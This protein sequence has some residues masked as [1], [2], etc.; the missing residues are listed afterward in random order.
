[1]RSRL[2]V[3]FLILTAACNRTENNPVGPT[4][5]P[6]PGSTIVYSAVGASDAMGIGSSVPCLPFEDCLTGM[7]YVAVATRQLRSQSF[8][9]RLQNL[10]IP[11]AVIGRDFEALGQ[12]YNRVIVGN[13]IEREMPFVLTDSTVVT[14]FAGV[15]DIITV[16]SALGGGAGGAN[17]QAYLDAQV[18]AFANDYS[19]LVNGVRSRAPNTRVIALNVPNVAAIPYF[20]TASLS[21][22]QA[23]QRLS[24]G[25]TAAVNAFV[26]QGV[27]VIDLMCDPRSYIPG[28]YSAD[29]H[30]NDAGYAFIA[31]EVVRAVTSS[32]YGIPRGSCPQ[33]SVV[34]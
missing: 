23:E 20:A 9:V 15:N 25:F 8:T 3:M 7:G 27:T 34:P 14:I 31:A 28:N 19:T 21:E 18:T 26:S 22:R 2:A 17:P 13:F 6:S 33:M 16:V 10:G 32:S 5:P 12:Q 24:I 4:A 11:T 29:F 1:M 30:P